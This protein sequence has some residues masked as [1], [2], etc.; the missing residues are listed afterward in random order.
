MLNDFKFYKILSF[1]GLFLVLLMSCGGGDDP[2]DPYIQPEPEHIIPSNLNLTISV[3]GADTDN[4]NGDGTGVIKCEASATDAVKYEFRFGGGVVVE[5]TTG[6][7]E[8]IYTEEG[9]NTYTVY[10]YAYSSTNDNI[11][12]SEKVIV[13]VTPES[14][15]TLIF[16]DEFN[17]EI[18]GS[19]DDSKWNYDI[20]TGDWGWGNNEAQYYTSRTDNVVVEDGLLK[21][22]AKKESYQGSEYTSTRMKTQGKFNFTYGRVEVRAKLPQGGGTWSAI[23]MLGSNITSVG[24]PACGEVDIMEHVGNNQGHV[25]SAMHTPSSSGNTQNKGG[26]NIA[27]VSSEFH[28]YVVEWTSE[29][30]IFMVDDIE[31]YRYSPSSKNM[32]NWPY[33]ANQFIILNV[34]M[35]GGMGGN[36]DPNFTQSSME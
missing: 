7:A 30:M 18:S 33:D 26:R 4:P 34:A 31:H 19:P 32:D 8:H 25:Q 35:G 24:W 21:I 20:G 28:V 6:K 2:D 23:W 9:T 14:F 29:E 22:T 27:T 13:Y 12:T 1:A 15:D 3:V 10:V 11:S 5:N 36:I 17:T 16:S